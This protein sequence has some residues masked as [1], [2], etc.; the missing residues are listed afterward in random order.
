MRTTPR[1]TRTMRCGLTGVGA[2]STKPSRLA[3]AQH[4]AAAMS[5]M[6]AYYMDS[7]PADQREPHEL[8]PSQPVSREHLAK[9]GVLYWYLPSAAEK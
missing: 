8:T 6:R 5:T 3:A 7:S 2:Q 4:S 1:A 9:L